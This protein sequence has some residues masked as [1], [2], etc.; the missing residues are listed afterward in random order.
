MYGAMRMLEVVAVAMLLGFSMGCSATIYLKP[1]ASQPEKPQ[2]KGQAEQT[3]AKPAQA[4]QAQV[5][6]TMEIEGDIVRSDAKYVYVEV[7]ADQFERA[8]RELSSRTSGAGTATASVVQPFT[9]ADEGPSTCAPDCMGAPA[10]TSADVPSSGKSGGEPLAPGN[11]LK[12]E[13]RGIDEVSHPGYALGVV[14]TILAGAGLV[15]VVAGAIHAATDNCGGKDEYGDYVGSCGIGPG[16]TGIFLVMIPSAALGV[17]PGA[18]M[19]IPG[20]ISYAN[21]KKHYQPAAS[22]PP[23]GERGRPRLWVAP[24][25]TPGQNVGASSQV[26]GLRLGVGSRW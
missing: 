2:A 16:F 15:G 22:T 18:A 10:S 24:V 23:T 14:G 12:I 5:K 7:G 1:A 9:V 3:Q 13:R 4:E 6:P 26:T 11:Y 20:W 21:S 17:L 8:K 25:R 19:M